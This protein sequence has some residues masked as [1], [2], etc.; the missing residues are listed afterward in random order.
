M[1]RVSQLWQ[2]DRTDSPLQTFERSLH[3]L[4]FQDTSL[5]HPQVLF[6]EI[7]RQCAIV[8]SIGLKGNVEI[9]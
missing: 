3:P 2:S 8:L 6:Q 9:Q 7:K 4:I 1:I 5:A